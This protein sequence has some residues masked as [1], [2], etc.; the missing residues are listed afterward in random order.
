MYERNDIIVAIATPRGQSALGVIRLSGPGALDLAA[1]IFSKSGSNSGDSTSLKPHHAYYGA[2]FEPERKTRIDEVIVTLFPAP[3]SYSGEDLVEI[4]CHGNPFILDQ[5]VHVCLDL[6]ARLARPGEYTFRAFINGRIDLVQAEAVCDLINAR[7]RSALDQSL[8]QMRGSLSQEIVAIKT[9]LQ[10]VYT[11]FVLAIDFPEEDV[12]ELELSVRTH[13]LEQVRHKL[14]KLLGTLQQAQL[15]RQ[16]YIVP[17]VGLPN[18]GKSS[19]L[20][21][22]LGRDR[23]IVHD[24]PGTTR[25]SIEETIMLEGVQFILIDTAGIRRSDDAVE[26]AGVQRT[27]EQIKRAQALIIMLEPQPEPSSSEQDFLTETACVPRLLIY[28]KIDLI[29]PESLPDTI[30][31]EPV[32]KVSIRHKIG[33][34]RLETALV[35]LLQ[36]CGAELPE[37]GEE[38][39]PCLTNFRQYQACQQAYSGISKGLEAIN[40]HLPDDVIAFEIEQAMAHL[41]D[42]VGKTTPDDILH[43]IFGQF[44]IGK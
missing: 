23:A 5:V 39:G 16:G 27:Y 32:Q 10:A 36:R 33:L 20:N 44:C 8:E 3:H 30:T 35:S 31:G 37:N 11:R 4:S 42:L 43:T 18:V 38:T 22:F 15:L 29:K 17:I 12:P 9:Q 21:H 26:S 34:D 19:L 41:D 25:D 14:N 40:Q 6:G 7:T 2:I 24:L 28:N 13:E 1:T